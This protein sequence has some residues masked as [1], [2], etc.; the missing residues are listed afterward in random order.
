MLHI[1]RWDTQLT[2]RPTYNHLQK[3][4]DLSLVPILSWNNN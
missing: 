1:Y 2:L 3:S 4:I